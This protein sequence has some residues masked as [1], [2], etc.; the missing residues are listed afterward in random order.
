[1][2]DAPLVLASSAAKVLDF[3][4]REYAEIEPIIRRYELQDCIKEFA[5]GEQTRLPKVKGMALL[6]S[7]QLQSLQNIPIDFA[8]RKIWLSC[9]R[10]VY[11]IHPAMVSE[12]VTSKSDRLPGQVFEFLPHRSPLII[13]PQPVPTTMPDG[14]SGELLGFYVYGRFDERTRL[15]D[16]HDERL[17]SLSL[18]FVCRTELTDEGKRLR[19]GEKYDADFTRMSV[20]ITG[21][22]FTIEE[23]VTT[24]MA[25]FSADPTLP[26]DHRLQEWLETNTRLA[27]N[28]LLYICSEE[29]DIVPATNKRLSGK[30]KEGKPVR[31]MNVGWTVGPALLKAREQ[32]GSQPGIPTG[33]KMAPH[34]RRAHFHTY[35]T[36]SGR[37]VPIIR[38]LNPIFVNVKLADESAPAKIVPVNLKE[39]AAAK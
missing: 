3:V 26:T 11:S 39:K 23:A 20:P 10:T 13:F 8:V 7:R 14:I 6:T 22:S 27:L 34:Q 9:G 30:T 16:S 31:E 33:R 32:H 38:W 24:T 35:W 21:K 29:P 2:Q 25:S 5:S 1:M 28:V 17:E 12:L 18:T 36:G 19:P 4:E 37:T 15:C